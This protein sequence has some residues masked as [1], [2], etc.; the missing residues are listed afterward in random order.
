MGLYVSRLMLSDKGDP[1]VISS[2]NYKKIWQIENFGV[3]LHPQSGLIRAVQAC[4][5]G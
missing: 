1:L 5:N 3:T 4:F 2:Q